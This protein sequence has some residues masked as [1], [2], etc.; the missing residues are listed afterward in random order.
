MTPQLRRIVSDSQ[1]S[2]PQ[3]QT[4]ISFQ[5]FSASK[6]ICS[7]NITQELPKAET[8]DHLKANLRFIQQRVNAAPQ[9][10]TQ[11][12][13]ITLTTASVPTTIPPPAA[14]AMATITPLPS[15]YGDYEKEGEPTDWFRQYRLSLPSTFSDQDKINRFE[16]Q[17]TAGSMAEV[18]VQNLPSASKA[19]WAT[20]TL[21]FTAR[22][23]PPVHVT[24]MLAQQKDRIKTITLKEE[25]IG[26]M[27]EKDR[28]REW[29]H[30]KWAKEIERTA[31]GFGDSRCLLLDVILEGTPAI[32]RDLLTEQY[33][34][35]PDFVTDVS[36]LSSSQ[37]QRAKQQLETEKKL[38]EDVDRLQ[39]QASGQKKTPTPTPQPATQATTM[40]WS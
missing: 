37:L 26:R 1:L 10:V 22:W 32:L 40:P 12:P 17:C 29:G 35:W 11:P 3:N 9:T 2:P 36:R 25:D 14:I 19:T 4:K 27:I 28:G 39:A 38:R 34:S 13:T 15:F 33:A 16:L 20:F 21:V 6:T 8:I 23:P 30:V 18:W 24:L 31:Q 5:D 7:L